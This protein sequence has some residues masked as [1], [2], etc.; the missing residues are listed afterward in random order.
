MKWSVAIMSFATDRSLVLMVATSS[1]TTVEPA[2]FV[3]AKLSIA[4]DHMA[5]AASQPSQPAK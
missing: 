2:S 5:I 4:T 3:V 1:S